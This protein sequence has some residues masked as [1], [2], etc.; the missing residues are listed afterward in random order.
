MAMASSVPIAASSR[1]VGTHAW[2]AIS[3]TGRITSAEPNSTPAA[4]ATEDDAGG[5]RSA[6]AHV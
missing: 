6:A 2:P 5:C 4:V 1:R 3:I